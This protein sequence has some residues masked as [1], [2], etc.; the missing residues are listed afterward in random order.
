MLVHS[1]TIIPSDYDWVSEDN[2]TSAVQSK[3]EIAFIY[4]KD[5]N[6]QFIQIRTVFF[7]LT[8]TKK[9]LRYAF[10]IYLILTLYLIIGLLLYDQISNQKSK[11]KN[12]TKY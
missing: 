3:N 2:S 9:R 11:I 10:V 8:C 6:G 1:L 12:L 4:G 7:P 5:E